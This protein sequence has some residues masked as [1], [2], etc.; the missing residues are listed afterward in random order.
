MKETEKQYFIIC[1]IEFIFFL[2]DAM[3]NAIYIIKL[4]LA[5]SET[6]NNVFPNSMNALAVLNISG[7]MKQFR[8]IIIQVNNIM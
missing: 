7:V 4:N 5:K 6:E 8:T 2:Q 3:Q 1:G